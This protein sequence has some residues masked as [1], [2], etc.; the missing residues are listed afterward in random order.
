[1]TVFLNG[2]FVSEQEA[3]VSVFDRGFQYGDGLFET[4]R[5]RN[6]LPFRW[7]QHLQRLQ[8][9]ADFLG[10]KLPFG[11]EE[12]WAFARRMVEANGMR[13][14]LLRLN[15]SRGVGPR[16]YSP[17]GAAHS[18]VVMSLN[19]APQADPANP[20]LWSLVVSRI[21]LAAG[22][23]LARF[24]TCN[25]LAQ[26]VARAEAD[27]SGANETLLLN[28]TGNVVE[29]SSANVF[30]IENGRISTPP[31]ES[32]A[33]PGVTRGVLFEL[34]RALRLPL[35]ERDVTPEGLRASDGVFL[36]LSSF[37]ILECTAVDGHALARS[38]HVEKL[39][40][41]YEE[42]VERETN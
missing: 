24:K 8:G 37:G 18:T 13:E 16:G 26:V 40:R 12:L 31:L 4:M 15:V 41:A 19:P 28:T 14:S 17:R 33:L 3:V 7:A 36:S 20:P 22:D 25:K 42:L 35:L 5:I 30:W 11:S 39:R 1:M 21:R 10:I 9:G 38:D 32:G 2:E 34:A 6:G 27:S 23:P 29:A